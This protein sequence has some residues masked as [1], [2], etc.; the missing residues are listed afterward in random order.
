MDN[1]PIPK[2]VIELLGNIK[3]LCYTVFKND[4]LEPMQV[5]KFQEKIIEIIIWKTHK[6][7]LCW[8]TT[9]AGKSL[10]I[11]LGIILLAILSDGEKIRV[12]APTKDHTKIIMNYIT[13]HI[14]DHQ[15]IVDALDIN[16]AGMGAER[17]KKEISKERITFKNNSE[18]MIITANIASSGRS[19]VGTGGTAVFIDETELIPTE[20]IR[21]KVMRML[22]DDIDASVF[23]ISNP[24]NR[25]YMYSKRND[26]SWNKMRIDWRTCV[27]EGRLTKEFVDERKAE[28]TDIEFTIWYEADYPE[29]MEDTLIP[30][31][32]LEASLK[33]NL[34]KQ[35]KGGKKVNGLDVAEMGNDLSVLT[36]TLRNNEFVK[37]KEIKSWG[38]KN[39]M[40]TAGIVINNITK[41][42]QTQI[43]STGVG[44]GV[45]DR[46]AEQD[47]NVVEYKGGRA[48]KKK[49][50]KDRFEN[51][52]AMYYWQLR[53]L[54]ENGTI[55]I[56]KHQQ[57]INEL[58]NMKYEI[59]SSGK[60]RIIKPEGKSPDFSDSCAY[61]I[62]D[63]E[64]EERASILIDPNN[65]SGLF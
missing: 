47:Y 35:T 55:Q 25:G 16:Y 41:E 21:S 8:A 4:K 14:L 5:S 36:K 26:L 40:Q 10:A 32:W 65:V 22:G 50:D 56:I 31:K 20:I 61:A 49:K 28:M 54:F 9:R 64:K 38:K 45:F 46:L 29:D 58:S 19:L 37:L 43:D 17:L 12:I 62:A 18:I 1:K 27:K 3:A 60:I 52:T 7:N 30:F 23:M 63:D 2:E 53:T 57:L 51:I 48:P 39:T 11:A 42:E 24:I 13:Q 44:K 6:R 33:I 34:T 59:T 15:M